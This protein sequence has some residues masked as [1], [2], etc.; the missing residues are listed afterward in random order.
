MRMSL[1]A[2]PAIA[3]ISGAIV[4]ITAVSLEK[5][6]NSDL[7]YSAWSSV[8]THF[9]DE[10]MNGYDWDGVLQTYRNMLANPLTPKPAAPDAVAGMVALLES[11]HLMIFSS[12]SENSQRQDTPHFSVIAPETRATFGITLSLSGVSKL[13]IV[14][15][16]AETS[17]LVN[18]GV[19]VGSRLLI[20]I[21]KPDGN[22]PRL[23]AYSTSRSGRV[24][25]FE[26]HLADVVRPAVDVLTPTSSGYS[27]RRTDLASVRNLA[28]ERSRGLYPNK[29]VLFEDLGV[30]T[31]LGRSAS[32]PTVIAVTK[33]SE[34][35]MNGVAIGA[36]LSSL[37][38]NPTGLS[39]IILLNTDGR[40]ISL[41]AVSKPMSLDS[42]ANI[43]SSQHYGICHVIA[44]NSF[45]DRSYEW[46]RASINKDTRNPII[47]D[48]RLNGGGTADAMLKSISLFLKPHTFIGTSRSRHVSRMLFSPTSQHAN[49][50][51]PLS[52]LIGPGT[53]S[54]AEIMASTFVETSRAKLFGST[55]AGEVL[56]AKIFPLSDGYSIQIPVSAFTNRSGKPLE[57][58]GVTPNV[59]VTSTPEDD[60]DGR[61]TVLSAALSAANC[62][63]I[64]DNSD[65]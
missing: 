12:P 25:T 6:S 38:I 45:S 2:V 28:F 1:R 8:G 14:T 32:V 55:T 15:K 26:L 41:S 51:S 17:P 18:Q 11:S 58:V 4:S 63:N 64:S 23:I 42:F 39:S 20:A 5:K 61:D 21:D 65:D 10:S 54:A 13:P 47:L 49:T 46:L 53:G 16:L 44:F 48:L 36:K 59:L 62:G 56:E 19:R 7:L 57:G 22:V 9:Y 43:T 27:I 60:R 31:T 30:T 37:H 35:A 3:L 29:T 24:Q 33:G 34:A 50:S 40:K 52:L